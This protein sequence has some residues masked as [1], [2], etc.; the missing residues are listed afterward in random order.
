[1]AAVMHIQPALLPPVHPSS[2]F[3]SEDIIS[4]LLT[5]G[6]WLAATSSTHKH[7]WIL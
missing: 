6:I 7:V 3:L 2:L 5:K 4:Q 1:M